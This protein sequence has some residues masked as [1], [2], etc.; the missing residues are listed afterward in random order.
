MARGRGAQGEPAGESRRDRTPADGRRDG[1]VDD[2]ATFLAIKAGTAIGSGI[3]G[4]VAGM[5]TVVPLAGFGLALGLGF[6]GFVIPAFVIGMRGRKR[7]EELRALPDA[8]DL[9][10]VSVEAGLGFDGAI[11]RS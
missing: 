9:L 6:G 7:R 5:A 4:F 11:T 2:A 8:L 3:L 1:P 10:A